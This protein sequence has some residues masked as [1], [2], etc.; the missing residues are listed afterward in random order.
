VEQADQLKLLKD[1]T[2]TYKSLYGAV[3]V[4]IVLISVTG[5]ADW[6]ITILISPFFYLFRG[7]FLLRAYYDS[8]P[9]TLRVYGE[10]CQLILQTIPQLVIQCLCCDEWRNYDPAGNNSIFSKP[11]PPENWLLIVG[12]S[13]VF[14]IL[15]ICYILVQYQ[16]KLIPNPFNPARVLKEIKG[17][18]SHGVDNSAMDQESSAIVPYRKE[19]EV[20]DLEHNQ[21]TGQGTSKKYQ[22]S[23]LEKPLISSCE[24]VETMVTIYESHKNKK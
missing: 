17:V 13:I 21:Q 22:E 24:A 7:L 20:I 4:G 11:K 16:F 12:F 6:A 23:D 1:H 3:P 14:K 5:F 19:D 18:S 10:G 9:E 2:K 8:T 15:F